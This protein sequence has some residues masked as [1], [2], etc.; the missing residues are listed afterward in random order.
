MISIYE[1]IDDQSM[2]VMIHDQYTGSI[3]GQVLDNEVVDSGTHSYTFDTGTFPNGLY[4]VR[5]VTVNSLS[6]SS[7]LVNH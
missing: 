5:A 6:V 4:F 1:C 7:F 2:G 3:I